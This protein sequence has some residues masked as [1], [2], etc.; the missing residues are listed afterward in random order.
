MVSWYSESLNQKFM[1]PVEV[2]TACASASTSS[3]RV[4]G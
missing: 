3:C 2:R 4:V 1:P